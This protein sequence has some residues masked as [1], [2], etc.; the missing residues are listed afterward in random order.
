M[1]GPDPWKPWC[2]FS[3]CDLVL[4][5]AAV[6]IPIAG[7]APVTDMHAQLAARSTSRTACDNCVDTE[8][9]HNECIPSK[10]CNVC[11]ACARQTSPMADVRLL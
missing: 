9:P 8:C 11:T 3:N 7:M 10:T 2:S 5:F 4:P 6:P 1:T